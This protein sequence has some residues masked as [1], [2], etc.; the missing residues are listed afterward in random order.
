MQ[1][2]DKN[3]DNDVTAYEGIRQ[4]IL[5]GDV[6]MGERIVEVRLAQS[7]GLSRTPVR[8]AL[9]RLTSDGLVVFMPNR[10]YQVVSYSSADIAEIYSCRALL[11]SEAVRLVAIN[12]LSEDVRGRLEEI[13]HESGEL[14]AAGKLPEELRHTFSR[15]NNEFHKLLYAHCGNAPLLRMIRMVTEIPV[16]IR[17]YFSFTD[18]EMEASHIGHKQIFKAIVG[19]QTDRAAALMREHIWAAKDRMTDFPEAAYGKLDRDAIPADA[20]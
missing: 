7:L 19:G 16:G 5:Q 1:T 9:R 3:K 10:G 13:L 20:G 6:Q 4:M 14:F 17:N 12:G 15:L 11:E 18:E 8:E 2:F